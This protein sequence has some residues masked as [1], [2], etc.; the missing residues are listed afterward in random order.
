VAYLRMAAGRHPD[1]P[2]L[3]ALIGELS[4]K[5]KEFRRWW[6]RHDVRDKTHGT[7]RF[8][9][10]IVGDLTLAFESLALPADGDQLLIMYTAEPGSESETALRLLGSAAA[11]A[12]AR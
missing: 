5:S 3:A 1:D 4:M 9:H 2:E 10:P 12:A 11:P 7:K 8:R 6:A